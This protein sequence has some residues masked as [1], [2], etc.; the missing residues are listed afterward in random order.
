MLTKSIAIVDD[1]QDLVNLFK[2]AL[3]SNGFKVCG[4]TNPVEALNQIEKQL[5]V[6]GLVI[7][8]YKMPFMNGLELDMKLFNLNPNLTIIL[9]SAYDD[10][11]YDQSKFYFIKKPLYLSTLMDMVQKLEEQQATPKVQL[12]P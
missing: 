7:T 4:Y 12:K 10:I 6:Y 5:E 9:M 8:D 2:A 1:E 3:E 11:K